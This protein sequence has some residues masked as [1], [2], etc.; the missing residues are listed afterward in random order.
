LYENG[1]RRPF[2]NEEI[3]FMHYPTFT[4]IFELSPDQL[5]LIPIGG[6]V[7]PP[8]GMWIKIQSIPNVYEVQEDGFTLRWISSEDAALR[9]RGVNWNKD[10]RTIDVTLWQKFEI[11]EKIM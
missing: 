7:L 8:A 9:L 5:S 11:G 10:I 6:S 2:L 1:K 3:Y 4:N